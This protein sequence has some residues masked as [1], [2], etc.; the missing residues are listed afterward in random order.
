MTKNT[1]LAASERAEKIPMLTRALRVEIAK[2]LNM[3]WDQLGAKLRLYSGA[4]HHLYNAAIFGTA[5]EE[6]VGAP[7]LKLT[8]KSDH[9]QTRGYQMIRAKVAS[10]RE[11]GE[12]QHAKG[13]PGGH[14]KDLSPSGATLSAINQEAWSKYRKWR[15]SRGEE[16]LPS[17]RK[18]APIPIRPDAY[19]LHEEG[20][21][22][23]LSFCFESA[24]HD[25][26]LVALRAS[27]G[28]HWGQMLDLAH[29]SPELK[30]GQLKILQDKKTNRWQALI[31]YS[32]P[33][34][35]P[36][37]LDPQNVLVLHRGHRNL[38]T[39]ISSAGHFKVM[40]RG[41]KYAAQRRSLAER[42]KEARMIRE[43]ERG[44]GAKGHGRTRRYATHDALQDKI[45]R[46]NTTLCQQL[47]SAVVRFAHAWGCGRVFLEDYGGIAPSPERGIRRFVE[48]FPNYQLKQSVAWA[49]T[50][51][52]LVLE[53]YASEFI[54]SECPRCGNLDVA[55]HNVRTNVF[56]CR[57][58]SYERD[59]DFVAAFHGLR[60][61]GADMS[62]WDKRLARERS[63][64]ASA[65]ALLLKGEEDQCLV[66]EPGK[67]KKVKVNG[68]R[69]AER[70]SS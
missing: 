32:H 40:A 45:K 60:R 29:G 56:H 5:M 69:N 41:N 46:V 18:G 24:G 1:T 25:T 43:P 68:E 52:G 70:R 2:P 7:V 17:F 62:L 35:P 22:V 12:K 54:S 14:Y 55:Q 53:E 26:C 64:A 6:A 59:A 31:C 42:G 30:L 21:I 20:R 67:S 10:L 65:A 19:K 4:M 3:S 51:D 37:D 57:Q 28:Y 11:W 38:L 61:S 47:G 39:A 48:R 50:K 63:L 44:M 23:S 49:L 15:K 27:K 13:D 8:C 9:A 66:D 16:S 34:P 58:C 33:R 36:P